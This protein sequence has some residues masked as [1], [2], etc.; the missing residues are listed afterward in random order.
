MS[1]S[2]ADRNVLDIM[3]VIQRMN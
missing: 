2:R 3:P 1:L